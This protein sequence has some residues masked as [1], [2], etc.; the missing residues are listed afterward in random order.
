LEPYH[1]GAY[2]G[3]GLMM[4]KIADFEA[5]IIAFNAAMKINPTLRHGGLSKTLAY[6]HARVT[7]QASTS[8]LN[9]DSEIAIVDDYPIEI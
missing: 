5:A 3:K 4:M 1:Y 2:C 7:Q 6:C 9:Q 8:E